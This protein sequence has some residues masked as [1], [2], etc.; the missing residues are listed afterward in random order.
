MARLTGELKAFLQARDVNSLKR[1][2]EEA[3]EYALRNEDRRFV[4]LA[5]IAYSFTKL[6]DKPYIAESRQLRELLPKTLGRLDTGLDA[7]TARDEKEY[8][9]QL[10]GIL[11]DIKHLSQDLGRFVVNIVDKARVKAA[12]Q[13]YAHG[14]SLGRAAEMAG[15]DKRDLASYVGQTT[16]TEKYDTISVKER[17]NKA[18]KLFE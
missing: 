1:V 18:R 11:G 3:G 7:L 4:A 6:F 12:T 8:D 16:L 13:I 9:S 2:A 17:L 15:V 5:T 14:A 10:S